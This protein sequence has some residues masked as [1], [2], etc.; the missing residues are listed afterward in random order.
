MIDIRANTT[1][2]LGDV[3][4]A[5]VSDSYLQE[6]G[7]VFTKG[8]LQ[9]I[10]SQVPSPG[11]PVTIEWEGGGGK[12]AL[13]REMFVLSSF[14]DPLRNTTSVSLGCYLTWLEGFKPT[15][16]QEG[17]AT[18][19]TPDQMRCRNG[20]PASKY[21]Q[22]IHAQDALNF[23]C[24][25]LGITAS[26][27]FLENPYMVEKL[28]CSS[29]YINIIAQLLQSE[30]C[31][32][33]SN[34]KRLTYSKLGSS[35]GN[36]S[37]D[38]SNIIDIQPVNSGQM[39]AQLVTSP[40]ID[41]HLTQPDGDDDFDND[42]EEEAEVEYD[43]VYLKI[44]YDKDSQGNEVY[45]EVSYTPKTKVVTYYG[46]KNAPDSNCDIYDSGVGDL[47]NSVIKRVTTTYSVSGALAPDYTA[48]QLQEATNGNTSFVDYQSEEEIVKTETWEYDSELRPV[49]I[50]SITEEP[51]VA[52]AG[53]LNP[54][55]ICGDGQIPDFQRGTTLGTYL[56]SPFV[57]TSRTIT[58]YEYTATEGNQKR[59]VK[60]DGGRKTPAQFAH[61][62][63]IE[64]Q[65]TAYGLTQQGSQGMAGTD[66]F[67]S[68]SELK[69]Y[70]M[71]D[72]TPLVLTGSQI[73]SDRSRNPIGGE[74]RPSAQD[75]AIQDWS[76]YGDRETKYAGI[77][78]SGGNGEI[79]R[80]QQYATPMQGESYI[81]AIGQL[82]KYTVRASQL[83]GEYAKQQN[84]LA[85]G[86]RFGMNVQASAESLI[87]RPNARLKINL[88]GVGGSYRTNGMAWQFN[89]S[90]VICSVD[91]VLV[92]LTGTSGTQSPPNAP[93]KP[94]WTP[95][96]PGND[97]SRPTPPVSYT[98]VVWLPLPPSY[99]PA[100]P[101]LIDQL[102]GED[103]GLLIPP[104]DVIDDIAGG[105]R[106]GLK[107]NRKIVFSLPA[108]TA[109][110]GV[111]IGVYANRDVIAS[112][113]VKIG[114]KSELVMGGIVQATKSLGIKIG[115]NY[116]K[117]VIRSTSSLGVKIG[118]L[119]GPNLYENSLYFDF[120]ESGTDQPPVNKGT[121]ALTFTR[122]TPYG[123]QTIKKPEKCL[124]AQF[125]VSPKWGPGAL[126]VRTDNNSENFTNMGVWEAV[127]WNGLFQLDISKFTLEFWVF[128]DPKEEDPYQQRIWNPLISLAGMN[129]D[130]EGWLMSIFIARSSG[131][132]CELGFFT[133]VIY[134]YPGGD[135]AGDYY[136]FEDT[137]IF[138][139]ERKWHHVALVNDGRYFRFYV[140]GL[141]DFQLPVDEIYKNPK[142]TNIKVQT[143]AFSEIDTL[144]VYDQKLYAYQYAAAGF[145]L[146]DLRLTSE[147][148]YT[149]TSFQVPQG[150]LV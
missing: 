27:P 38:R 80:V 42:D 128:N 13:P 72:M 49:R 1:C 5:S 66:K 138:D 103:E 140:D 85:F 126:Y 133:D 111:K 78:F 14:A 95:I 9:I 117:E 125:G 46:E 59:Y 65:F 33:W 34:G 106:I 17:K 28:D 73:Q 37:L 30:S 55:W 102:P 84:E 116:E 129:E 139:A 12:Q 22:P 145:A 11:T 83:A 122:N 109:E 144:E 135:D 120:A 131:D 105:I 92:G 108:R 41:N 3:I 89:N 88:Q 107:V 142:K 101:N 53:R 48:A 68:A 67:A 10:G 71:E 40:Y 148:V 76:L 110:L 74:T 147:V 134:D 132:R 56:D 123:S 86:N 20:D 114:V 15:P 63:M 31:I 44:P 81:D 93:D 18:Y 87:C 19:I 99:D 43:P 77:R 29:G 75:R 26:G 79:V 136:N 24:A 2:S 130:Q 119:L 61:T 113:G 47:S 82:V 8:S 127:D 58:L 94:T 6:A 97:P 62:K 146:D 64:Q 25:A 91:A 70:I 39:A 36:V 100:D 57:T 90:G 69:R 98:T 150:P 4:T 16:L 23:C 137:N 112:V 121:A 143:V 51:G 54:I 115:L 124:T 7:L 50:E 35:S 60:A 96:E 45:V 118:T 141:R 21:P 104:Y 149:G 32:G 52:F